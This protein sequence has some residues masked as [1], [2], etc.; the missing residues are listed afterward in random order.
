MFRASR[1][2]CLP[3]CAFA[4]ASVAACSDPMPPSFKPEE[5]IGPPE[6]L[7]N[8]AASEEWLPG[9][10]PVAQFNPLP[11][12]SGECPF[13]RGA[14]QNFLIATQPDADA[15]G[16]P[17]LKSYD[18]IDDT[19]LSYKPHAKR[20]TAERAWLGDIKQ[21]GGR[22]ILIDQNGHTIYYGIHVNQAFT[23]FIAANNLR[24]PKAVQNANDRLFFP[25]GVVEFKSAW[26]EV[27]NPTP[28]E[29]DTYITTK[30]W[31][32]TLSQDSNTHV[33]TEDKDKP[34]EIT[35]RL[36]AL[37]V[38]FTLPGHPEFIWGT[39]EHTDAD[40]YANETDIDATMGHRDVA[41]IRDNDENPPPEDRQLQRADDVISTDDHLLY[42]AGTKANEG[43]KAVPTS[44]LVLDPATQK[45]NKSTSA[46]R[47][48]PASKSNTID[49]DEAIATLN[50][51]VEAVFKAKRAQLH[52]N[53]RRV[54]YR[55]V[56]AQWLD[57]PDYFQLHNSFQN[58][59][60]SPLLSLPAELG[61][62]GGDEAAF[63]KSLLEEGGDS[64]FSLTAGED[65]LSS[66]GME[67]FT[68]PETSFPNCFSCHNTQA[69]TSKGI[70]RPLG[71]AADPEDPTLMKPKLLNVSHVLSQFILE[72]CTN[73]VP[74]PDVSGG[75]MAVCP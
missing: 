19:F 46:F 67:T 42:K 13:Y 53:D 14:W 72:E 68:Q 26:Q 12:P 25:D 9:T 29:T 58:N 37:H 74:D 4:V 38:V 54:H 43:N 15:V 71:G 51:N 62:A 1:F 35:V 6:K 47:I 65:R 61:G 32:P 70:T 44:E 73:I 60:T 8:C 24:T 48:F 66:V 56:G 34:R 20:G 40:V 59:K 39:F 7:E 63:T 69:I 75:T 50:H 16:E 17:A 22:Q 41:P 28:A 2:Y 11:H 36:L 10:P 23:D 55:L 5:V 18:T 33:V 3:L 49:A 30:A 31:V 45:F 64:A 21:A 57:K 27:D 52:K